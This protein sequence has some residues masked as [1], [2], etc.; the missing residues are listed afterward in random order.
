MTEN[1][2]RYLLT[3]AEYGNITKA[4]QELFIS[5]PSLSESLSKVEQEFG[6]PIFHRELNGL[7]PTDFGR[8][9]LD[10]AGKILELYRQMNL[11]LDEYRQMRRGTL[12]FGIPFNLGAYV[13]PRILPHFCQIYPEI[14]VHF[15]ENNSTEL[16]KLML[17]GKLDFS[18]MHYETPDPAIT[19]EPLAD[20]PFYL[21]MPIAMTQKYHFPDY[22]ELSVYDLRSLADEPFLMIASRQKLRQVIDAI[23]NQLNIRPNIRFTT[24][25][26]ETAKRL[27]AA[28][29]GIT[30]LPLSYLT[31]FSGVENLACYPLDQDLQ[32]SWKL[33][34]GYP[35]NRALSRCSREFI[36]VLKEKMQ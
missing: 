3:I 15:K 14:T 33:V 35:K 32:A 20:D 28:G 18:I 17:S 4:A 16:D 13:L 2:L 11:D 29:M 30:F 31:L 9:Y 36:R 8:K 25:N 1:E 5:Q 7:T 19:Y 23:L 21:V 24:K 26:M 22:R 6:C 12:N 10:T 27:A 34:V